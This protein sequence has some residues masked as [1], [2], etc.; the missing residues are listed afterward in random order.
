MLKQIVTATLRLVLRKMF[1]APNGRR[2][3]W[4]GSIDT[5]N[6]WN[7]CPIQPEEK[8]QQLELKKKK[9]RSA[10]EYTPAIGRLFVHCESIL[11]SNNYLFIQTVN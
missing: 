2:Y 4:L 11:R 3:R 9:K 8:R 7:P 1:V 5:P 6:G 10:G